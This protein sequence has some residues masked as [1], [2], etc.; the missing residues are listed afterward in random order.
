[1]S[2]KVSFFRSARNDRINVC[3]TFLTVLKFQQRL[4]METGSKISLDARDVQNTDTL[5][6]CKIQNLQDPTTTC[7][8]WIQ[9]LQDPAESFLSEIQDP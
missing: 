2:H 1:M 6:L 7:S 5:L 9:D 8:S 3:L 4:D